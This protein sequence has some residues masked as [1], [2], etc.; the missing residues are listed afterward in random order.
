MRGSGVIKTARLFFVI[1]YDLS[2]TVLGVTAIV[3][4]I[5]EYLRTA[6]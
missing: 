3:R 1:R 4:L 5:R 6:F 2:S